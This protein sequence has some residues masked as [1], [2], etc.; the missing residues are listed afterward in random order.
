MSDGPEDTDGAR[1]AAVVKTDDGF[2]TTFFVSTYT[3]HLV[4]AA[5]RLRLTP[6]LVTIGALVGGLGAA[7]AF[8]TGSRAGLIAGAVLLQV[9]FTLDVVDG[10]LARYM[11]ASSPFGAWFDSMVDRT[12]E[13]VVYAGLA[14]GSLRGFDQD[15]WA[16]AG[17]ALALQ[18][19]RH[20]V[21][22]CYSA[23]RDSAPAAEADPDPGTGTG[24]RAAR[25]G[26]G[27]I[28]LS[29]TTD[30]RGWT[31][32]SKR[33][34]VLPIGE[35]LFLVS[36]TAAFFRPLVTF[37]A[38]LVWGGL[39]L[40]YLLAGR[41]LRSLAAPPLPAGSDLLR[42]YRDDGPLAVLRPAHLA[43]LAAAVLALIAILPWAVVM[44]L[45]SPGGSVIPLALALLWLLVFGV[46]S[47][48][49]APLDRLDW[50]A[51]PLLQAAEYAGVLRLAVIAS[52]HDLAAGYALA[53]V[54]AFRHY[55]VVYRPAR[56]ARSRAVGLL[57]GG[58]GLRLVLAF[59]LA[60]AGVV[61]PG[62]YVFAVVLAVVLL[63]EA[64][65]TWHD[66][67]WRLGAP[68]APAAEEFH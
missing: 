59:G 21:D 48:R 22:F 34:V 58:W 41:L 33:I 40:V 37:V 55:D 18:A 50:L 2:F 8:A 65:V 9:S 46:L 57:A 30:Q 62:D 12:K 31:Y 67:Q 26:Q 15:V 5:A 17:A 52:D 4:R 63:G 42:S 45:T 24:G 47:G 3:P 29:G 68:A 51:P 7:A 28:R 43:T 16:L 44:A 60:A 35:R 56:S 39:A 54:I 27:A 14:I 6:N 19:V 20:M 1:L 53:G 13:Y 32:W 66:P 64:A 25:L 61:W 23:G 38:L 10:Q 11:G 36:V 49:A